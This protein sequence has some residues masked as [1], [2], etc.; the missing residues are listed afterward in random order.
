LS[1]PVRYLIPSHF[2]K[3]V[4]VF[5]CNRTMLFLCNP[6]VL[7]INFLIQ[8]LNVVVKFKNT[9]VRQIDHQCTWPA[10]CTYWWYHSL[11]L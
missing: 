5:S 8:S 1:L 6:Q 4:L 9:Y 2:L 10:Q 3:P 11:A 7:I